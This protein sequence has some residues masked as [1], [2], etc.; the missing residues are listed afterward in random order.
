MAKKRGGLGKGL[1]GLR[2]VNALIPTDDEEEVIE[3]TAPK[4]NPHHTSGAAK[5]TGGATTEAEAPDMAAAAGT[6]KRA[7]TVS[8]KSEAEEGPLR[9]VRITKVEPD[10]TQPRKRFTDDELDELAASIKEHGL[11]QPIVVVQNEGNDRYTIVAGER[12]WRAC[13][14]AG[15]KEVQVI[16]RSFRDRQEQ[17]EASLIENI[18]RED[19]NPVEE[20]QAFQRLIDEFQLKQEDVAEKV[21]KSRAAV[22]N[23]LRLLKLTEGVQKMII[24]GTL[25]MGHARALIPVE[26]PEQQ[27]AIAKLIV[28]KN[29]SVREV[30]KI[31]KDLGKTHKHVRKEKDPSLEA[32]YKDIQN[33]LQ[34]SLGMNVNISYKENKTGKVEIAFAGDDDLEKLIER[35]FQ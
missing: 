33:R 19:L 1:G 9:T 27:L 4:R 5:T 14:K 26:D 28:E 6:A 30:E 32:T 23:S 7:K 34:Q 35:I 18:Q 3:E 2:G 11:L 17:L 21:S 31:V 15:L 10:S 20:A 22:A 29:L 16:V 12:R 13:R 25:S 8:A 24:D